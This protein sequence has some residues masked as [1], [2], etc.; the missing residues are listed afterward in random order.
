MNLNKNRFGMII[1]GL[2]LAEEIS[3]DMNVSS[4]ER[5]RAEN[6]TSYYLKELLLVLKK[7]G[8]HGKNS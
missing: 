2:V 8:K 3:K 7:G 4:V 6:H 5:Q 1:E